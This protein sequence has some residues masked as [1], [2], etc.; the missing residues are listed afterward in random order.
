MIVETNGAVQD[1]AYWAFSKKDRY[2][3][4]M[5]LAAVDIKARIELDKNGTGEANSRTIGID[6]VLLDLDTDLIIGSIIW[7]GLSASFSSAEDLFEVVSLK[8]TPDIKGKSFRREAVL[9][10]H[11]DSLP[12]IVS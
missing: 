1:F 6:A 3:E 8:K 12:T 5:I 2:S 9:R 11:K 4:P 10:R 7:Q